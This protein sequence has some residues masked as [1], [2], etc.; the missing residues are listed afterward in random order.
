GIAAGILALAGGGWWYMN[1]RPAGTHG[2]AALEARAGQE[3]T[4]S[5]MKES[6]LGTPSA[7]QTEATASE[8]KPADVNKNAS[9]SVSSPASSNPA[10]SGIRDM[11]SSSNGLKGGNLVTKAE[12]VQPEP[13]QAVEK[14]PVLGEVHLAAPKISQKR[15]I[16]AGA[17][18]DAGILSD[19]QPAADAN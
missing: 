3:S 1:Q 10:A 13:V 5:P 7:H 2:E 11:Q 18:P 9:S 6:V 16:Q 4:R 14:K 19:D 17:A 15:T 12:P 8:V